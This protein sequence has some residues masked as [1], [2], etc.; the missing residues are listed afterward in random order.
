MVAPPVRV[1]VAPVRSCSANATPRVGPRAA[2]PNVGIESRLH[3]RVLGDLRLRGSGSDGSLA[4]GLSALGA[5]GLSV[6]ASIPIGFML[7]RD[8]RKTLAYLLV[9]PCYLLG[10][11]AAA[12]ICWIFRRAAHRPVG[13]YV[14]G[15]LGGTCMYGGRSH[16]I[17]VK[18]RADPSHR[19]IRNRSRLWASGWSTSRVF[20]ARCACS[21]RNAESCRTIHRVVCAAPPTVIWFLCS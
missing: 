11:L 16:R 18:S 6:I 2:P 1:R 15:A 12:L 10:A 14:V 20:N 5:F 8:R 13:P 3:R 4:V 9:Y 17:P 19:I 21:L 7:F